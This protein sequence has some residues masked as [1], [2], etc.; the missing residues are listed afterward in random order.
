NVALYHRPVRKLLRFYGALNRMRDPELGRRIQEVLDGLDLS[1]Q[2]ERNAGKLSR[3]M[4]QRVGLAQALIN[5]PQLVILDEPTSALDPVARV[6]VRELLLTLKA[7][8]KTIFLSSHMLS[9]VEAVSDRVAILVQG[10]VA[11]TGRTSELLE[12]RDEVQIVARNVQAQEFRPH[13][14]E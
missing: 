5:D 13:A 14:G 3:G 11:K 9:E 6:A 1:E 4:M 2:A 8:G 10:K 7:R 12:G